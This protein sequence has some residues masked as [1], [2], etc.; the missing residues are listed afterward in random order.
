M[1]DI[2]ES[3]NFLYE[4]GYGTSSPF[5]NGHTNLFFYRLRDSKGCFELSLQWTFLFNVILL[6]LL[7]LFYVDFLLTTRPTGKCS[8]V[9]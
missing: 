1:E 6:L 9:D 5:D 8:L 2:P 3:K 7:F 4:G